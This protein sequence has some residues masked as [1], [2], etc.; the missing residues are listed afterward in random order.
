MDSTSRHGGHSSSGM[1]HQRAV[2]SMASERY[3]L[4]EMSDEERDLFEEHY[5]ECSECAEDIRAAERMR[6]AVRTD[7][8]AALAAGG[9]AAVTALREI[10]ATA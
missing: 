8:R 3:L 4:G 10:A 5:F 6:T 7:A 9:G 2:E 1:T